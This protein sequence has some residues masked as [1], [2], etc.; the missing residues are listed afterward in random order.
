[1]LAVVVLVA[2]S[3]KTVKRLGPFKQTQLC[4]PTT[5]NNVASAGMGL[6]SST[7]PPV[8]WD[9]IINA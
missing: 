1:M 4:W 7:K 2:Y 6:K 9:K 5:R 3:V 8:G